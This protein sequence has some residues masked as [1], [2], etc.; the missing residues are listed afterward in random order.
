MGLQTAHNFYGEVNEDA[1]VEVACAVP[2]EAVMQLL[3]KTRGAK[4]SDEVMEGVRNFIM[5]GYSGQQV[6]DRLLD[7][8]INDSSV[9]DIAKAKCATLFSQTD[10]KL[11][12][13]CDEELQLFHLFAQLRP[14]IQSH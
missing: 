5:E 9:P 2:E 14:L 10:E 12:Q 4:S 7:H 1:L 13:G 6:L 11:T 3:N 8:L